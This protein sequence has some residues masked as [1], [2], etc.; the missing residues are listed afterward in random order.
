VTLHPLAKFPGPSLWAI[1]RIPFFYNLARGR[2]H[3]RIHELHEKYGPVVRLAPGEISFIT[4]SAW[5]DIYLKPVG[6]PQLQK[7]P[8]QFKPLEGGAPGIVLEQ[9]DYHHSRIRF[10]NFRLKYVGCTDFSRLNF[11]G[12]FTETSMRQQ[13]PAIT[14]HIDHLVTR[15]NEKHASPVNILDWYMFTLVDIMG[16]LVFGESFGNLELGEKSVSFST[17]FKIMLDLTSYLGMA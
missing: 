8:L 11:A 16:D 4:E 1:S 13:E 2:L 9:D 15:L 6:K 3:S 17:F 12:G 7:E 10:V 14:K 5:A